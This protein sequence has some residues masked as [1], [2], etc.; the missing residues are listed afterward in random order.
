[1]RMTERPA[2]KPCR[3]DAVPPPVLPGS[4]Y[5]ATSGEVRGAA[6]L[7]A[8]PGGALARLRGV[9]VVAI[10]DTDTG[11][12]EADEDVPR[13]RLLGLRSDDELPLHDGFLARR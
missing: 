10:I 1:M 7:F 11:A 5:S 4:P 9:F 13:N 3:L 2:R 12:C 8:P 6:G